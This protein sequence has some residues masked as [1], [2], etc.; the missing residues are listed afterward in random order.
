[1][2]VAL[3]ELSTLFCSLMLYALLE[4]ETQFSNPVKKSKKIPLSF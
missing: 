2:V 3:R 1:M 4:L